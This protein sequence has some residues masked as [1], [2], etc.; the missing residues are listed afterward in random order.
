MVFIILIYFFNVFIPVMTKLDLQHHYSSFQCHMILQKSFY[1]ADL[2]LLIIHTEMLSHIRYMY[3]FQN[4]SDP[5]I[6]CM[7][8]Y[9]YICMC[10]YIYIYMIE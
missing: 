3:Y 10:V 2:L 8:M 7:Y 4:E 6:V 5:N 9:V 1:Y